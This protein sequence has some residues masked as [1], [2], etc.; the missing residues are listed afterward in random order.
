M[1]RIGTATGDA[2][3]YRQK[4]KEDFDGR[5][6]RCG[7]GVEWSD[8]EVHHVDRNRSNPNRDNLENLCRE[9]HLAEHHGDDPLWGLICSLPAPVVELLDEAVERHGY[10]SRSEAVARAVV[11]RYDS[12][13]PAS[14][15][16]P[17]ESVSCWFADDRH[18]KWVSDAVVPPEG[19]EDR[20]KRDV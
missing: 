13:D 9:C 20:P 14:F 5:C 12:E 16:G 3:G 15:N 17:V 19:S 18:T 8:A 2:A 4:A 7:D 11:D 1:R 10:H 6:D